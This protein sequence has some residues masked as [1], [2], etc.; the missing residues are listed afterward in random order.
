MHITW[1]GGSAIK[2]QTKPDSEER[3]ILID[4]YKPIIGTFPRNLV[5]H[6]VLYTRG[7]KSSITVSGN[8]FILSTPGEI[9]TRG[10]L[11]SSTYGDNYE[12]TVFRIDVEHMSIGHLGLSQKILT[13]KEETLL[14]GVDILFIPIGGIDC[15]N[16]EQAIKAIN[17]IEPRIVIPMAYKNDTNPKAADAK[18]FLKEMGEPNNIPKK[19]V[20]LKKKDLPIEN[21]QIIV[22]DK[23]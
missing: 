15:Y 21:M 16:A 8:P 20:I 18:I 23:E 6:L 14:S 9:E 3:T 1:L 13:D 22:L 7:E 5:A 11:V 4:P 12:Q 17:T 19:K 2:L 10:I